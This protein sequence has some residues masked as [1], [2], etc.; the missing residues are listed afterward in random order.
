MNWYFSVSPGNVHINWDGSTVF[1][2]RV[3]GYLSYP[4]YVS[5]WTPEGLNPEILS[6]DSN[7]VILD[8]CCSQE[9]SFVTCNRGKLQLKH[10]DISQIDLK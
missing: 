10:V 2:V 1:S 5:A 4:V 8:I 7:M 6:A 9:N 3:W